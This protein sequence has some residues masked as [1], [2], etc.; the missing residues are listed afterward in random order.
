MTWRLAL[1]LTVLSA[2]GRPAETPSQL[3]IRASVTRSATVVVVRAIPASGTRINALLPPRLEFRSGRTEQLTSSTLTTD[4]AYYAAPPEVTLPASTPLAGALIRA[5]ISATAALPSAGWSGF[6]S[7]TTLASPLSTHRSRSPLPLT[8]HCSPFTLFP[9]T[10][11]TPS[12]QFL[13]P[14]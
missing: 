5:S 13:T 14:P 7:E 11:L 1:A 4:S 12:L 3:P 10:F 6:P 2:C 9:N 8:V